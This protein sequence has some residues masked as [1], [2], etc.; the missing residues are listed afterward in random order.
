MSLVIADWG[1]CNA[2]VQAIANP[3]VPSLLLGLVPGFAYDALQRH[4]R[5]GPRLILLIGGLVHFVGYLGLWAI[6][7]HSISQPP[8]WIV[9]AT[10]VI[11]MNGSVWTDVACVSAVVR[12]FPM[13]RG[14]A[15][16]DNTT[17]PQQASP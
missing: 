16:G 12:S 7:T 2:Q 4:N 8:Y 5:L 3:L 1:I 11:A 13:D 6:G 14:T 9:V 15:I 10:G 17:L